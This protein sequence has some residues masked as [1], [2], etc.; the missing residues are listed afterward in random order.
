MKPIETEL[1]FTEESQVPLKKENNDQ[2]KRHL[3]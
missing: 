3:D 2:L 1:H